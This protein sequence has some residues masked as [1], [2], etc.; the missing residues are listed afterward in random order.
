VSGQPQAAGG[1]MEGQHAG[2]GVVAGAVRVEAT[3]DVVAAGKEAI[4][5][6]RID[7]NA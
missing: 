4:E 3:E 5:P 7:A 1:G 2:G 6:G